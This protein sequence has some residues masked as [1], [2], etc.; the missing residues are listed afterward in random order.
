VLQPIT[1]ARA[2]QGKIDRLAVLAPS[3]AMQEIEDFQKLWFD[4][5]W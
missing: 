4:F 3:H 1:P 5:S 2:S